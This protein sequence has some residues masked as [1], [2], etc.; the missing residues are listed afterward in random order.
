[1]IPSA[2]LRD[3][4]RW[5][6][7][8]VR[9]LFV[10]IFCLASAI[11]LG[12]EPTR[13]GLVL[14]APTAAG[15]PNIALNARHPLWVKWPP[16]NDKSGTQHMLLVRLGRLLEV[17]EGLF[18]VREDPNPAD[19]SYP[20]RPLLPE[21]LEA[22]LR[23]GRSNHLV[24]PRTPFL[25]R[26]QV[27]DRFGRTTLNRLLLPL[28]LGESTKTITDAT[29]EIWVSEAKSW[30]DVAAEASEN[31]R[32]LVVE[33][34][35]LQNRDHS[36]L[37][38]WKGFS[39]GNAAKISE[40]PGLEGSIP[41]LLLPETLLTLLIEP[42]RMPRTPLVLGPDDDPSLWMQFLAERGRALATG[43]LALWSILTVIGFVLVARE[44]A[45]GIAVGLLM[46]AGSL[47]AIVFV[48]SQAHRVVEVT[49][50]PLVYAVVS[51]V[52]LGAVA[53]LQHR[54]KVV[55]RP[56]EDGILT[57]T[58]I[59]GWFG[60]ICLVAADPIYS[61]FSP[62]ARPWAMPWPSEFT[63]ALV[64]YSCL[65]PLSRPIWTPKRLLVTTT[66]G[67][68]VLA[69]LAFIYSGSPV[70]LATII[71]F[72]VLSWLSAAGIRLHA[73]LGLIVLNPFVIMQLF[74]GG[75]SISK[76]GAQPATVA[77]DSIDFFGLVPG[78]GAWSVLLVGC[79]IAGLALFSNA[80]SGYRLRRTA[81]GRSNLKWVQLT[82]L[83]I[84]GLIFTEPTWVGL[85]GTFLIVTVPPVLA[86]G[87]HEPELF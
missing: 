73:A 82:A 34:P 66:L 25:L 75:W 27:P 76:F 9:G 67:I 38:L 29:A 50:L 41:G 59:V 64:A 57:L 12:S 42:E 43:M 63:A 81:F 60:T 6:S 17:S 45:T 74:S 48:V 87:A 8:W 84:I 72:T 47:P 65:L 19:P 53:L 86:L 68:V 5:A 26:T 46:W 78:L 70:H 21:R 79:V 1:M 44:V 85:G 36:R 56:S 23:F 71:S 35:P 20:Y 51:V 3:C 30:D 77:E 14:I 61:L 10:L 69:K 37:W 31:R 13:L 83:G 11:G 18:N 39:F 40:V 80:Y 52:L 4:T 32:V 54:V 62:S 16:V 2:K 55:T 22:T 28:T 58:Q 49:A 15:T 24:R 7:Q 33:Y